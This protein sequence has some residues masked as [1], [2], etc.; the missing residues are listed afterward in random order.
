[1]GDAQ[2]FPDGWRAGADVANGLRL[3]AFA[4]KPD[5]ANPPAVNQ[6]TG[7]SMERPGQATGWGEFSAGPI[8]V[9]C[10]F[11]D[12]A[13]PDVLIRGPFELA[14]QARQPRSQTVVRRAARPP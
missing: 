8:G 6:V 3:E 5:F 12:L 7:A 2:P 9:A 14:E 4:A 1:M 10:L 11:G 13:R